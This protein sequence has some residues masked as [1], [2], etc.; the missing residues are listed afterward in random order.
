MC[1]ARATLAQQN[2]VPSVTMLSIGSIL[3]IRAGIVA[4]M[5]TIGKNFSLQNVARIRHGL[6]SVRVGTLLIAEP[7]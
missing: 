4:M 5:V 7:G 3:T 6:D 2:A 1:I